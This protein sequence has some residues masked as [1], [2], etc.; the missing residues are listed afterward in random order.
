MPSTSRICLNM[1]FLALLV[2]CSPEL[3]SLM[4]K[5]EGQVN[6]SKADDGA[7]IKCS[8]RNYQ[9]R[10]HGIGHSNILIFD[11]THPSELEVVIEG[12]DLVIKEAIT[13]KPEK[14]DVAEEPDESTKSKAKTNEQ[15]S[16]KCVEARISVSGTV[17]AADRKDYELVKVGEGFIKVKFKIEYLQKMVSGDEI[18]IFVNV[19]NHQ[20]L[21]KNRLSTVQKSASHHPTAAYAHRKFT[22]YHAAE[23]REKVMGGRIKASDFRA[24]PLPKNEAEKLFG[25]LI[26]DN[27]YVVRL[28][29]RNTTGEDK[30]ISTG[31]ITAS[32][33]VLVE[34]DN[35]PSF[36]MPVEL[37]PSSLEQ[38]YTILAD[39]EVNQ[40]RT[41]VFRGLEFVGALATAA[42]LAFGGSTNLTEGIG[43]FTGVLIPETRK[44]WP[45]RWPDYQRNIVA[46][47]MQDLTKVADGA[48]SNQK[49]LFFSKSKIEGV[50]S[51]PNLFATGQ[52]E[53]SRFL[54]SFGALTSGW[55]PKQPNA[56][57]ISV[58][59]DGLDIP[60]ENVVSVASVSAQE[61]LGNAQV[62]LRDLE[63]RM[64]DLSTSWNGLPAE[65][66]L[67]QVSG[68]ERDKAAETI[69]KASEHLKAVYTAVA[70]AAPG[71][72]ETKN[73]AQDAVAPMKQTFET[74][75]I[76][77]DS[78]KST[79]ATPQLSNMAPLRG[80]ALDMSSAFD[81]AKTELA[82]LN[83]HTN[84]APWSK[85]MV[86]E[87]ISELNEAKE[88][89]AGVAKDVSALADRLVGMSTAINGLSEYGR[90]IDT[91]SDWRLRSE[92][93]L[94]GTDDLRDHLSDTALAD[95]DDLQ[96]LID[97]AEQQITVLSTALIKPRELASKGRVPASGSGFNDADK[98]L[99]ALLTPLDQFNI[100]MQNFLTRAPSELSNLKEGTD[101]HK[102]LNT[103]INAVQKMPG[104]DRIKVLE[105]LSPHLLKLSEINTLD[106]L[107]KAKT[108][109]DEIAEI[110]DG[111]NKQ[112]AAAQTKTITET[113]VLKLM[114]EVDILG[115]ALQNADPASIAS[116]F[117]NHKLIGPNEL[118]FHEDQIQS[119]RKSI[120]RGSDGSAYE[121][122]IKAMEN[123][124]AKANEAFAIYER[125]GSIL[126]AVA[127]PG[128]GNAGDIL[129]SISTPANFS[130]TSTEEKG[131]TELDS[132]ERRYTDNLGRDLD[133]LEEILTGVKPEGEG[134]GS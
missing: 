28:S 18:T 44:L 4:I 65:Q 78:A 60:F 83:D 102:A 126:K 128:G 49:L 109:Y 74:A 15:K 34:P 16:I 114:A 70:A 59:F 125:I 75:A 134:A 72:R 92:E 19:V 48:V 101:E 20:K 58:A 97:E 88:K 118:K 119:L 103:A 40:P 63:N 105:K 77:I 23:F 64:N 71:F 53:G 13:T 61:R 106:I 81:T 123:A 66:L 30:L 95:F 2:G 115:D 9:P 85:T 45:D 100:K 82:E 86:T 76:S 21:A 90:E 133:R 35:G 12:Q 110:A 10:I 117:L 22:V 120:L 36:T 31:M 73:N 39:E 51:D 69:Q 107:K 121:T 37:T 27:F 42:N 79:H 33:R 5:S 129:A 116:R 62:R 38:A 6:N 32:G 124:V 57:V 113:T 93:A 24:F 111:I 130:A 99:K 43:L 112:L 1:A 132:L 11:P 98:A 80:L 104:Y 3:D 91:V 52:T 46:F 89:S 55:Q 25:P 14:S 67:G 8:G 17:Q 54:S 131:Q 56:A 94:K 87:Q 29:V 84:L 7:A 68:A 41:R 96:K 47:A 26:A 122:Q 127:N 108:D 50:M